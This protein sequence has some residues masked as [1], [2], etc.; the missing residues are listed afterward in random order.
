[1]VPEHTEQRS[2]R[3][4]RILP[5][6]TCISDSVAA[7]EDVL[8]ALEPLGMGAGSNKVIKVTALGVTD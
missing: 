3:R 7:T 6:D 8:G 5:L 4:E 2:F 1:M